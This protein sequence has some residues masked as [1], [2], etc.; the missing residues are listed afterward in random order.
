MLFLLG[1]DL[2]KRYVT[3]VFH[4]I[5]VT[6]FLKKFVHF[7]YSDIINCLTLWVLSH[8]QNPFFIEKIY[9]F[10]SALPLHHHCTRPLY[11]Q[12]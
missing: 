11:N 12:K 1:G 8:L 7:G 3:P 10:F 5:Y 6:N 4:H 2:T 9:S